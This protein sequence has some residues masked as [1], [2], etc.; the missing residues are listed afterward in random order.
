MYV[1]CANIK[2]RHTDFVRIVEL[3]YS[4]ESR[5]DPLSKRNLTAKGITTQSL[6]LIGQLTIRATRYGHTN[7][8]NRP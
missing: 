4:N 6:K 2:H 1:Y 5:D 7:G 3:L 8:R